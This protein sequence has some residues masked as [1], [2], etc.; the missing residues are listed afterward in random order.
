MAKRCIGIDIGRSHVRAVQVARTPEGLVIEKAF[1]SQTRRSTD[2]L[3]QVLR[4]LTAEHGFDPRAQVAVSMPCHTVS[5]VQ[6][7]TDAAGLHALHAPDALRLRDNLPVP[8]ED[9]ILRVCSTRALPDGTYSVLVAV[10]SGEVLRDLL[11]SLDEARIRPTVVDAPIVAMQAAITANYPEI[12]QTTALLMGLDESTLTLAV[13]R[14]T[15]IL[16]ARSIPMRGDP[17]GRLPVEQIAEIVAREVEITWSKLFGTGNET[18]LCVFLMAVPA[19]AE[20]LLAPIQE[21]IGC[22]ITTANPYIHVRRCADDTDFPVYRA[23]GLALRALAVNQTERADFLG[24]YERRTQPGHSLRKELLTC[25]ALL[26]VTAAIWLAGLFVRLWTLESQ[27]AEIKGRIEA[28]FH[29]ALP[30]ERNVVDPVAQLQQKLDAFRKEYASFSSFRPGQLTALEVMV[31]L[32]AHAP[33]SGSPRFHDLLI[34]S[35]S[36]QA[37]GS[38][39]SFA[40]LSEWESRLKRMPG[41]AVVDVRDRRKDTKTGQVHFTLSMSPVEGEP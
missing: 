38:C 17:D 2:S 15:E 34:T 28:V 21:R 23:E 6:I 31:M 39:D 1:G 9:A 11:Q 29:E 14:D 24:A 35:G 3:P 19:T 5:F 25:V 8:A 30:Q 40:V 32:T 22:R 7:Q 26:T 41:F 27:Y 20:Q 10:T 13:L 12:K 18:D 4:R 33:G 37:L 36:V 16:I